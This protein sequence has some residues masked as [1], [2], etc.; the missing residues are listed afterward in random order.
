V[1]KITDEKDG[2]F[3]LTTQF[4]GPSLSLD[5]C[6]EGDKSKMVGVIGSNDSSGQSGMFREASEGKK[7]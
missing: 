3:R 4:K 2:Y 7:K 6:N 5:V 1:W